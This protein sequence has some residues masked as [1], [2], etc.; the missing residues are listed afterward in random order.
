MKSKIALIIAGIALL[1][2]VYFFFLRKDDNESKWDTTQGTWTIAQREA[3]LAYL[4]EWLDYGL[5]KASNQWPRTT[6]D[7]AWEAFKQKDS[8]TRVFIFPFGDNY[9][10]FLRL[11][12]DNGVYD[13]VKEYRADEQHRAE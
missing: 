10:D 8:K 6:N 1:A 13:K 7:A 4:K 3:C 11:L 5:D 12:K 9:N 2:I